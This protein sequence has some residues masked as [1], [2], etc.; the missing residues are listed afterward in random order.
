M[1]YIIIDKWYKIQPYNNLKCHQSNKLSNKNIN[2]LQINYF[3]YCIVQYNLINIF[4]KKKKHLFNPI[5]PKK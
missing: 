5:N 1:F 4:K 2:C 3:D